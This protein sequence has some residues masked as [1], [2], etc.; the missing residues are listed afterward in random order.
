MEIPA[1]VRYRGTEEA[2]AVTQVVE[3]GDWA[4][5]G[6]VCQRVERAMS[7]LLGNAHVVLT[8]SGTSAMEL[9]LLVLGIGRSDEVIL[10][11]FSSPAPANAIIRCGATPVFADIRSDSFNLDP[12]QLIRHITDQTKAIIVGHYGGISAEMKAIK[13]IADQHALFVIEDASLG[14]S[15]V[16]DGKPLGTLAHIGCFNFDENNIISCGEGGAVVTRS[17]VLAQQARL[18][19]HNDAGQ[20]LSTDAFNWQTAGGNFVL[21]DVLAAV[22]EVQLGKLGDIKTKRRAVWQEYHNALEVLAANGFV[23]LPDMPPKSDPNYINF[24]FRVADQSTRNLLIAQLRSRGIFAT[25]HYMPLHQTPYGE[26]FAREKLPVAESRSKTVVCLPIYPDLSPRAARSIV[27]SIE[28]Y[29]A[30]TQSEYDSLQST[31]L[32]RI[33][34]GLAT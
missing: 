2:A 15:S 31:A 32:N 1:N 21:S 22:L 12:R 20:T 28:K 6:Y 8:P 7:T 16:V 4:G 17:D 29:F 24:F 10:P 33:N 34:P 9:A 23:V 25:T 18:L 30:P 19:Q 5:G 26:Q 27:R 13:A 11:T 14:F 3:S